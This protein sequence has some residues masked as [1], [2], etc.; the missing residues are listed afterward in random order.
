MAEREWRIREGMVGV[1]GFGDLSHDPHG[2]SIGMG[3]GSGSSSSNNGF[4]SFTGW[5]TY[6]TTTDDIGVGKSWNLQAY[7]DWVVNQI[8]VV[9]T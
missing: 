5:W 3:G 7:V 2:M 1:E 8:I 6:L 4:W 9:E